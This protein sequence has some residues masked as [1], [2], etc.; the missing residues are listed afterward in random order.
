MI[1]SYQV[2]IPL[3]V[4]DSEI[5][6]IQYLSTEENSFRSLCLPSLK[7]RELKMERAYP[8]PSSVILLRSL[9]SMDQAM[10]ALTDCSDLTVTSRRCRGFVKPY[11]FK[12]HEITKPKISCHTARCPP[13]YTPASLPVIGRDL[14]ALHSSDQT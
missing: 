12:P 2:G 7:L 5:S 1:D 10:T 4:A 9:F 14:C 6:G 11:V 13:L 8:L 3:Y